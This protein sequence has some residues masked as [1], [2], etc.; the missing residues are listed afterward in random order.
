MDDVYT[1]D[2]EKDDIPLCKYSMWV[3]IDEWDN[4]DFVCR[5]HNCYCCANY[6]CEDYE[7]KKGKTT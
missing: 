3:V 1:I 4:Q 7:P 2:F 5:K 6:R